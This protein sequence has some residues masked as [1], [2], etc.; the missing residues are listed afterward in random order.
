MKEAKNRA[1]DFHGTVHRDS[2]ASLGVSGKDR[3]ASPLRTNGGHGLLFD[4]SGW[5]TG[6]LSHVMSRQ[7]EWEM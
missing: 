2:F 6:T 5:E 4:L 1:P 7:R 3:A